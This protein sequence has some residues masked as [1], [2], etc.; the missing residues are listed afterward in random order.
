MALYFFC[1]GLKTQL[2]PV[3]ARILEANQ[4]KCWDF[5][6]FFAATTD[7][8]NRIT[9]HIFFLQQATTHNIYIHF[10]NTYVCSERRDSL[11]VYCN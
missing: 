7:I 4:E 5:V 10:H 8:L 1:R 3:L 11:S 9:V 2:I 6:K